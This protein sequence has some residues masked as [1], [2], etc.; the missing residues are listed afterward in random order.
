MLHRR[1]PSSTPEWGSPSSS[2]CCCCSSFIS[3]FSRLSG[4]VLTTLHTHLVSDATLQKK[5]CFPFHRFFISR[6]PPS[7]YLTLPSPVGMTLSSSPPP[8]QPKPS[9]RRQSSQPSQTLFSSRPL[10]P[11]HTWAW[12]ALKS[13]LHLAGWLSDDHPPIQ[14]FGI[15]SHRFQCASIFIHIG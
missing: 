6:I 15:P 13:P 2:T 11:L 4:W 8:Q 10:V 7:T 5:Q 1:S 9:P 12:L 14:Q 3:A